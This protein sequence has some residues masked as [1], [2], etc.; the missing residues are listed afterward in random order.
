MEAARVYVLRAMYGNFRGAGDGVMTDVQVL[1]KARLLLVQLQLRIERIKFAARLFGEA[2]EELRRLAA[3]ENCNDPDTCH[4]LL[5]QD[6]EQMTLIMHKELGA[7]SPYSCKP[8]EWHKLW[9]DFP[10][11]WKLL[12][13]R[14]AQRLQD[15]CWSSQDGDIAGD[16]QLV[17]LTSD[18]DGVA[19]SSHQIVDWPYIWLEC[20]EYEDLLHRTREGMAF[21]HRVNVVFIPG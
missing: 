1:R 5:A 15:T 9:V 12:V 20:M 11:A 7:T 4:G 3:D 13:K 10:G 17:H 19:S 2:L 14:F 16:G 6:L 21:A 8:E 18:L